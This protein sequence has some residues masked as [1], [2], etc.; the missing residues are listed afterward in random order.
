MCTLFIV[1]LCCAVVLVLCCVVCSMIQGCTCEKAEPYK[2]E[3]KSYYSDF[4]ETY[5]EGT[6]DSYYYFNK[7]YDPYLYTYDNKTI[8]NRVYSEKFYR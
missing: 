1:V 8:I 4:G 3:Y 2:L 7:T 6:A 5:D